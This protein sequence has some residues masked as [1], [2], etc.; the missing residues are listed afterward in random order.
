[1]TSKL[2][3][4]TIE[5]DTGISSV[6]FASSISMD[7]TAKFHFSAAGVDI[8]ADTNIN[9][10]AAGVLGFNVNGAE[11]L[12]ID[13]NGHLN[14]SGI[15]TAAN[16]KTGSSNLHSTGLTVGNNFLHTTGINVGTGATIHVP[17]TNV[18]TFGTNSNER[19][20]IT[21]NG[22]VGVNETD[23]Q[24]PLHVA[25]ATTNSAP[26]GTGI[27]MGLQHSHAVI[28][29]NAADNMGCL[30]D[31]SIPG[32][33]R[34]GG[35]LYYHANNSVANNRDAMSFYTSSGGTPAERLRIATG[36]QVII[37]DDDI[38]KANGNFDDLI[39][40]ANASTTETHGI[41]I[42]CGNAA[43]NGGIAFSDGSNGG[44][45]AYRGMI[46][47]Q[48]NDNHMQF[49][50]NATERLR[51]TSSGEMGVNTTAPVEKL[52]ISGNMRFVNP[53]GTTSRITALPSGTYSTGTSGGS[54]ICFQRTADGGGGS[55]EIFFETHWQGNRHGESC[56]INKYGNLKF[57]SGQGIDFSAYSVSGDQ[58]T[59]S[60]QVLDDFEEGDWTCTLSGTGGGS[61]QAGRACYTKVGNLV[62]C[63]AT[64][65]NPGSNSVSGN[66]SMTLPFQFIGGGSGSY[67]GGQV[68]YTRYVPALTGGFQSYC[69]FTYY[70]QGSCYLR[71]LATNG[72]SETQSVGGSVNNSMLFSFTMTYTTGT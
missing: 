31:F 18:L 45:D 40:G 25:G 28:H 41:T 51:I 8:G 50:T 60:A 4:N 67:G 63:E 20:R 61:I 6:S 21:S 24:Y 52:G 68:T 23:P 12:R 11:K 70:G 2:V 32:A 54:A 38:D 57:P 33:D 69:I 1:M 65:V 62:F 53:N 16:F 26:T 15:V 59:A 29:L 10:P 5:A 48:H 72:S 55:D 58:G 44:A 19:L 3:V 36:G 56:R 30:I 71:K 37:G 35:I 14:T 27:L 34:R 9:R 49:R 66:W 22:Y 7:S 46:S 47:Y 13:T 39:V 42:V 64:F 17:A 43:T